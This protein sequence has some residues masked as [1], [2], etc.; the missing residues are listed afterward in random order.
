MPKS[1]HIRLSLFFTA[2]VALSDW[3][4][5]GNMERELAV[6]RLLAGQLGGV[7]LVTYG[8]G[9]DKSLAAE[10]PEFN[11]LPSTWRSRQ[12]LTALEIAFRHSVSLAQSTI[13]KTNQVRGAM[14]PVWLKK[15]YR[16]K[17]I[18]RCGFL[19]AWFTRSQTDDPQRI[20]E[21]EALERTAFGA[22]DRVVVTSAWQKDSVCEDYRL[23][24]DKVRVIPNYVESEVFC[25][26]RQIEEKYDLVFVGRDHEQKN[27]SGFIEA[28]VR[29]KASGREVSVLMIGGCS[30]N[31]GSAGKSHREGLNIEWRPNQPGTELPGIINS[32]R[33]F[34]LPSHYEGHPKVL[35]EAMSCG[36]AC[37]GTDVPGIREDLIHLRNGYLCGTAPESIAAA[38]QEVLSNEALRK[39]IGSR[40]R[41]YILERY[42]LEQVFQMELELI[43]ELA[44]E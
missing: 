31:A 32:A 11:L 41:E 16:K 20:R 27:L 39:E 21:A 37:I 30:S 44:A 36:R 5:G 8:A 14:I 13:F 4:A 28:L 26:L 12:Q 3:K 35:L 38:I 29:L 24:R 1:H 2:G 15:L 10:L 34:I 25:P 23:P 19:H 43:H 9:R 6:Y 18:V 7:D 40:A 42:S 22:A 17:L 33:A